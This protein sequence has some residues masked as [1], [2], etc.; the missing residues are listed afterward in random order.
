LNEKIE[1]DVSLFSLSSFF[2]SFPLFLPPFFIDLSKKERE[3]EK[4]V[5][6]FVLYFASKERKGWREEEER[7][8]FLLRPSS[9]PS[10]SLSFALTE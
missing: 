9:P 7:G 1:T 2:P 10:F 4:T 8:L 3:R 5:Y 6:V